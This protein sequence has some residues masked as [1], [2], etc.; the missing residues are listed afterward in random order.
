MSEF[1][2]AAV[3]LLFELSDEVRV[4]TQKTENDPFGVLKMNT[5]SHNP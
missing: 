2:N 1:L 3:R 4:Y 5:T